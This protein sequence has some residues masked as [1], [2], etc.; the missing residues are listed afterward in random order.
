MCGSSPKRWVHWLAMAE[1]WYNTNFHTSIAM[2]PFEALYGYKPQ[3]LALGPYLQSHVLGVEELLQDAQAIQHH[4]TSHLRPGSTS[5]EDKEMTSIV[6]IDTFFVG[7]RVYLKS[8]PYC[9]LS[10]HKIGLVAYKLQLPVHSKIHPVFHVSLLK[11]R[12]GSTDNVSST[13]PFFDDDGKVILYPLAILARR[14]VKRNNA[15]IPQ[16]LV[17]WSHL[18]DFEAT[19]EDYHT[20][21]SQFPHLQS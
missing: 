2:T 6:R 9:Q 1:F 10:L 20:I 17:R 8:K 15:A 13:L 12:V 5:Y 11:K 19:W 18:P 7:D 3:H 16:I 21:I 14:L 4:L